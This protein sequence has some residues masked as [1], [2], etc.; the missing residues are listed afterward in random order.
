[1]SMK[2]KSDRPH[3][4]APAESPTPAPARAKKPYRL[5]GIV[6][7]GTLQEMTRAVGDAGSPDGGRR[8]YRRTR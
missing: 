6:R 4:G 2:P 5:P 8:P 7:W 1:M 3:P